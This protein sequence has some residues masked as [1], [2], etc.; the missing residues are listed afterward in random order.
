ERGTG[1][2]VVADLPGRQL[3]P[4]VRRE[5]VG[6]CG[7][8]RRRHPHGDAGVTAELS[9]RLVGVGQW[10]AV[11][12]L[13]VGNRRDAGTLDRTGEDG[14]GP[15]RFGSFDVRPI[16]GLDVVAVDL[17]GVPVERGETAGV[18]PGVPAVPGGSALAEPV[19]VD[20]GNQVVEAL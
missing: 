13:A 1:S 5:R 12:A 9:D 19:N 8:I 17:D 7:G 3:R 15:G 16:D 4:A 20:D 10:L 14:G 6:C 11:R 18:R 2:Y